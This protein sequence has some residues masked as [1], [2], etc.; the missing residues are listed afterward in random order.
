MK[1]ENLLNTLYDPNDKLG[2]ELFGVENWNIAKGAACGVT[3]SALSRRY[4]PGPYAPEY[5]PLFNALFR[6]NRARFSELLGASAP[7]DYISGDW[8][9]Y[10]A[11]MGHGVTEGLNKIPFFTPWISAGRGV[12]SAMAKVLDMIG[13]D[14]KKE[15]SDSSATSTVKT[16]GF[17]LGSLLLLGAAGYGVYYLAKGRK[18]RGRH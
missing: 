11:D 17:G 10:V 5:V 18:R 1:N 7:I 13:L 8:A 9:R 3:N 15:T 14:S 6:P 16:V 2:V 12:N 4:V